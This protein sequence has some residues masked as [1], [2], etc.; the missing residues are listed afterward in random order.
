M[1]KYN[2]ELI[3]KYTPQEL[4]IYYDSYHRLLNNEEVTMKTLLKVANTLNISLKEI[5]RYE[6]SDVSRFE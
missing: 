1:I 4:G 2:E 6:K 3:K 5:M